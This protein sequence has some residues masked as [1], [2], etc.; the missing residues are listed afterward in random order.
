MK[1][2][3]LFF[4]WLVS[5]DCDAYKMLM[6]GSIQFD[7]ARNYKKYESKSADSSTVEKG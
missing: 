2:I 4:L 1:K 7:K 5:W 3:A 6:N